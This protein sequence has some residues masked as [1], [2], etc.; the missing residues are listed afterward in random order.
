MPRLITEATFYHYVKCPSWVYFDAQK[1]PM[2]HQPLADVL[3]A[4]G[5]LPEKEREVIS[6]RPDLVEVTAE[7]PEEAFRQTLAF[8]R[9][10]RETIYHGVLIDGHWVGTPDVLA[11]VSERSRLGNYYYVAADVKRAREL[12]DDVKFQGCFYAELLARVQG[13]KPVQGYVITPDRTLLTYQI[14]DFESEFRLT[15]DEIE[16]IVAGEKP[17]HFLT[18]GCKQSPWFDACKNESESCDDLSMLNR[19]WREEVAALRDAGIQ[20]VGQLAETP[21]AEL[22]RRAPN[23]RRDRLEIMRWQAIALKDGHHRILHPVELPE[24]KTELYFDVESDPLRDLD[25]M[26]GVLE[27]ADGKA[28]YHAFVASSPEEEGKMWREFVTFIEGRFQSPVY[29][30]GW[31][32]VEVVH[33]LGAKYGMSE[34]VREAFER[35]MV[36][37][38]AL[39][40]P[41]VI[42]PL[43]FY[44]LKDIGAYMGFHWR[45]AD[46]SG[47]NAIHWYEEWLEKQD[48]GVL[49]KI[50]EYNEDDVR[51]TWELKKWVR[52]HAN[53]Y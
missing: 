17:A 20:T 13:I 52:D 36:D 10:G 27:V 11:K 49:K 18:S 51:A 15:L 2:P 40:R 50:E 39:V 1:G 41:A 31:Y 23:L 9:E 32:E 24:G 34:L 19:V 3:L 5:L 30:Y 4:D 43:S 22:E 28:Q 21:L 44:S 42:F 48:P 16:R 53:R 46:A 7:D 26:L 12:R 45:A 37:L 14:A 35:N 29:H 47:V 38:L 8:M 6:D 33:R 25:F